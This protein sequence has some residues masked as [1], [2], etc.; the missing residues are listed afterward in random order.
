M[1]QALLLFKTFLKY[2]KHRLQTIHVT[3]YVCMEPT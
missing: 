2:V 1:L 3:R